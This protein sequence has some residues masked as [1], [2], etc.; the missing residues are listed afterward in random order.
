MT[1]CL[2]DVF[3]EIIAEDRRLRYAAAAHTMLAESMAKP[4]PPPDSGDSD[5][6]ESDLEDDADPSARGAD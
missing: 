1:Y 2:A 5:D 3:Q 6:D 4:K